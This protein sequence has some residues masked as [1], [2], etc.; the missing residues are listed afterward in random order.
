MF[1]ASALTL[2]SLPFLVAAQYGYGPDPDTTTAPAPATTKAATTAAAA[3]SVPSAPPS[4]N[5]RVNVDVAFNKTLTFNP[6]SFKAPNGT[7]V[8]FYFPNAGI[9]HSVTQ[10]SFANPCTY[11]PAN[12]SAPA[13]FDSGLTQAAQ[14]TI[15]ITNDQKPIWF[16][17]KSAKHCGAGMVGA[18]NAPATGNT[19]NAFRSAALAIGSSEAS[20]SDTGPVTGGANAQATAGPANTAAAG[21]SSST[22]TASTPKPTNG[23]VQSSVGAGV[24]LLVIAVAY[25]SL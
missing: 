24:A 17:C 10:S 8:T 22:G 5:G 12:G 9:S 6:D 2:L 7:I 18:I 20:Q 23:A 11:L 21:L 25:I 19:F 1:Y 4:S 16:Y 14:F 15:T 13:G 3:A